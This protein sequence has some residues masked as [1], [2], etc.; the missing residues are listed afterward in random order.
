MPA[1]LL[2]EALYT[3]LPLPWTI[4]PGKDAFD[5]S[6]YKR[7]VYSQENGNALMKSYPLK[8]EQL[9]QSIY[10]ASPY[11][12]WKEAHPDLAGGEDDLAKVH[13]S[14]M[15]EVMGGEDVIEME[16]KMVLIMFKKR[17]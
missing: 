12:R 15:R 14:R 3:T 5:A 11:V 7:I 1:N 4:S 13:V 9:E 6:S 8:L 17:E 16:V 10:S 2:A